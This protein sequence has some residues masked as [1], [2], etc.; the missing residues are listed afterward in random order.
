MSR[1]P[2]KIYFDGGC[3]PNP[4]MIEIAVVIR[5]R[6]HLRRDLGHGDNND[7]EWLALIEAATIAV[8]EGAR[9]CILIGDA[10]MVVNQATGT[11]P[12]R[13]ARFTRYRASFAAIAGQIPSL[14]IRRVARSQ[15]L[16]GIALAR[17]S[18]SPLVTAGQAAGGMPSAAS[19]PRHRSRHAP[20]A[21]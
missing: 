5:G 18:S 14:R 11:A 1:R 17:A 12:C 4:G 7:A 8:D 3:R 15:N 21:T 20:A 16:A 13:S 9:D 6:V 19:G 10:A 2:L